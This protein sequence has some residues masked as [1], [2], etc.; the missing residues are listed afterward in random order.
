MYLQTKNLLCRFFFRFIFFFLFDFLFSVKHF[1]N[2]GLYDGWKG[3]DG[4]V[5]VVWVHIVMMMMRDLYASEYEYIR[6]TT[7]I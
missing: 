2:T 7:N 5:C 3:G 4:M 1:S 6:Y